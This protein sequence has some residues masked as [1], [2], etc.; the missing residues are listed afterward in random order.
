MILSKS[1]IKKWSCGLT[2]SKNLT[3]DEIEE[4]RLKL[5]SLSNTAQYSKAYKLAKKLY[6]QHPH[7]LIFARYEAVMTAE[8]TVGFS[9]QQIKQRYQSASKKLRKLLYKLKGVDPV[10]G[11]SIKNEYYWFSKQP[12]KQYLLG[13]N[14]VKAKA[15]KGGYYSQGVGAVMLSEKYAKVGKIK[16]ALRW[17]KK[18]EKAWLKFFKIDSNWYNSYLFYAMSLGYQNSLKECDSA[19]A[20]AAKIAKK[21]K[22]WKVIK[23]VKSEVLKV[24][25]LIFYTNDIRNHHYET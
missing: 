9:D 10:L 1:K 15:Y 14:E 24:H 5:R 7:I 19:L 16:L 17:A 12:Y 8:G 2:V 23:E 25:K 4:Y 21:P 13:V 3:A 18:S 11:K 6:Q 22:T 20:K